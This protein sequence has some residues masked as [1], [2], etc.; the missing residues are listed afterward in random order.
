MRGN[1]RGRSLYTIALRQLQFERGVGARHIWLQ[2]LL[3]SPTKDTIQY[4]RTALMGDS[5]TGFGAQRSD[6]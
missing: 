2:V 5:E 4:T 3:Q 6:N 1:E